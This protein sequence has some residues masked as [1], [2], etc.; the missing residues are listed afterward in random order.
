MS[1]L[2]GAT[3]RFIEKHGRTILVYNFEETSPDT[4]E[5]AADSPHRVTS[6]VE[7]DPVLVNWDRGGTQIT[8]EM[9]VMPGEWS[10]GPFESSPESGATEV[11]LPDEDYR[12]VVAQQQRNGMVQFQG[13]PIEGTPLYEQV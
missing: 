8:A 2:S 7:R 4:Y 9:F 12:I 11:A 13:E 1:Q 5:L 6:V 3:R 10:E